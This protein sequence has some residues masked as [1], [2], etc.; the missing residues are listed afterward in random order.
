MINL[1]ILTFTACFWATVNGCSGTFCS[2]GTTFAPYNYYRIIEG[3]VAPH[4]LGFFRMNYATPS[5]KE[6]YLS[7][8]CSANPVLSV[9][10]NGFLVSS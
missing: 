4:Q 8:Y 6:P 3:V 2:G 1:L 7:T 10:F 5:S 9:L